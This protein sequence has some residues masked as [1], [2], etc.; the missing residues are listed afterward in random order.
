VAR[1]ARSFGMRL[2]GNDIVEIDH[3]FVGE[4]GIEMTDLH[5]LLE[6]SDYVSVNCDLNPTSHHLLG[7]RALTL[8][9]DTAVV[10]NTARGSIV[11]ELALIEALRTGRI[12]GAA[13]DVFET[14]PLPPDS[15]LR[16][17]D[18]VMLAPHNAN[19]SPTA[20]DRVHRR[21]ILALLDGLGVA[22]E[23]RIEA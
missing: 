17:L 20:W 13:L 3:V 16:S 8:M 4:V 18:N 9:K 10:I 2:L 15:P 21:T 5:T 19:S 12:G 6:K 23:G 11:D 14:E 1:R 22:H 7:A